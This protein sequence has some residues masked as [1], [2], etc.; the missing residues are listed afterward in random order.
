MRF[1]MRFLVHLRSGCFAFFSFAAA[2]FDTVIKIRKA[3][4]RQRRIEK[5]VR[6]RAMTVTWRRQVKRWT[7]RKLVRSVKVSA[8]YDAICARYG[9]KF[10]SKV[11]DLEPKGR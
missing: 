11:D 7:F 6:C 3:T 5:V 2:A 4:K 9:R 1:N 10:V 8:V